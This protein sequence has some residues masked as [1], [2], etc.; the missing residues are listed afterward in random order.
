MIVQRHE[1]PKLTINF[2][3]L[4][5]LNFKSEKKNLNLTLYSKHK[6]NKLVEN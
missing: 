2:I 5:F 4:L 6:M 3:A 1:N